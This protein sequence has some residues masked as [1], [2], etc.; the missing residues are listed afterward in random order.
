MRAKSA[1]LNDAR[2]FAN[3]VSLTPK[4]AERHGLVLNKDGQRRTRI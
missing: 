2:A 4:E 3:S 1:A